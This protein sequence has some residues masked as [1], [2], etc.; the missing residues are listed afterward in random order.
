MAEF[1]GSEFVGGRIVLDGNVFTNCTFRKVTLVFMGTGLVGLQN[2]DFADV[3]FSLEGPAAN[4]L[5]FLNGLYHGVGPTGRM[6]VDQL[7]DTTVRQSHQTRVQVK[8]AAPSQTVNA[9][10]A[11]TNASK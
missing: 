8:P 1:T 9:R 11:D 6:L 4:T 10:S 2:C 7:L 3:N 5:Q